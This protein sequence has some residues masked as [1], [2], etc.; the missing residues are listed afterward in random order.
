MEQLLGMIQK[1]TL[2]E[3]KDNSTEIKDGKKRRIKATT[4]DANKRRVMRTEGSTGS[5]AHVTAAH[6][7]MADDSLAMKLKKSRS[8]DGMQHEPAPSRKMTRARRTGTRI[9][10]RRVAPLPFQPLPKGASK[11]AVEL[12]DE[13]QRMIIPYRVVAPQLP[14]F[15]MAVQGRYDILVTKG[16]LSPKQLNVLKVHRDTYNS[17]KDIYEHSGVTLESLLYR[18]QAYLDFVEQERLKV[19]GTARL[20]MSQEYSRIFVHF[21]EVK[22]IVEDHKNYVIAKAVYEPDTVRTDELKKAD[23]LLAMFGNLHM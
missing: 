11:M 18:I 15:Q 1:M 3:K 17:L 9:N 20:R 6:A 8:S 12:Y 16:Q 4:K 7:P 22:H 19:D 21:P 13:M 10:S 5:Q 2:Q 14:S 23:D